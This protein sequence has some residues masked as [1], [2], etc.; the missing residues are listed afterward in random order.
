MKYIKILL[1]YDGTD[2][3]G[4]QKQKDSNTIQTI[5]ENRLFKITGES[6]KLTGASRTDSGVHAL[7]QTAVFATN[8]KLETHTIIKALNS[9]LPNDIKAI[10]FKET[11]KNFHPRYNAKSKIYFYL[12]S[13]NHIVSPFFYRHVWKVPYNLNIALMKKAGRLL[14]GRHDFSAFRGAG[15]GAKT[16]IRDIT[17]LKIES[18]QEMH[19][20]D[21]KIQGNF[22]K[23]S[24]EADAFMRHMVRNIVGTL[25]EIGR[26]KMD[27]ETIPEAFELKDRRK[28]GPT[29]PPKGLFLEKIK[30]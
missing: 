23:I 3:F 30:Y 7:G 20:M 6:I 4:W 11:D 2:Y 13:N 5:I 27:I 17:L 9:L 21:C 16:T 26:G 14:K 15:C 12:I 18:L 19:F 8:S 29:A 10:S 22:I 28:T 25:V 1:Q 24:I